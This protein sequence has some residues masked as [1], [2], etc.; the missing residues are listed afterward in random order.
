MIQTHHKICCFCGNGQDPLHSLKLTTPSEK[1]VEQLW[2]H[3]ICF[4]QLRD[5]SVKPDDLRDQGSIPKNARCVFCSQKL[6]VFGKHPYCFDLGD[7]HPPDRYWIH[8]DCF[9][10]GIH[11]SLKD[12]FK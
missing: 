7:K 1:E 5:D 6:P 10:H 9:K 8:A 12:I 3:P 2:V 4:D 11:S